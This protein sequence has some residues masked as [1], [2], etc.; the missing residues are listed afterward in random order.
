M[1]TDVERKEK[2]ISRLIEDE[3]KQSYLEYSMSVIVGR[4]LPDVRDGLKPVHRRIL[5]AM[6][7][8]SMLHN[9]PFKKSARIVGEVLGK[10]HP[11]GDTA[12]YESM[13]RMVQSFSLRSPLIQGQGNFGSIDG[14]RA[15]AMR[16]TEARLNKLS[17]EMLQDLDKET[18]EYIPNFDNSLKEPKV[19]PCKVPNLLINGSSGIA[20]GMATNMPPHNLREVCTGM[21]ELINDPNKTNSELMQYISGPD[22]PTGGIIM[23]TKGIKDAYSTGRGK[24]IVRAKTELEEVKNRT[25]IIIKEIPY[26]VNKSLL[27]E[28]IANLT[29]DKKI[30]GISDLRD[31][32]DKD[33]MRIMIELKMGANSDVVLNQLFRHT[34]LQETFG[35]INLALV[36]Y[37]P[38]IL[39]LKDLMEEF[40]KHRQN[41]VRKR[42][43]YDLK[44]ATDKAHLLE[45][46]IIALENIDSV[47]KLIK[48]AKTA[49]E[50]KARLIEQYDLSDKQA[51][52]IL[53]MRL[54]RLTG[55]EQEKVR[56]EHSKLQQ[57]I[58]ILKE[59]LGSEKKIFDIIK[60]ELSELKDKYGDDRRTQIVET[61]AVDLDEET[62][63][64]AEDAVITVTHSGYIK[65]LPI[66]TYKQQKRGGRGIV[67]AETKSDDYVEKLVIANTHDTMLFFTN[68]GKVH[69]LKVF[70]VPETGRYARGTAI[71][72]LVTLAKDERITA[73][74]NIKEFSKEHNVLF[75]TKKGI[76]KAFRVK[77]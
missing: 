17:E 27:I 66:E 75:V 26:M 52:A 4:A 73:F 60:H 63:I 39:S 64:K 76:I 47:I 70:K 34:R 49:Q 8:M 23:G 33:G 19:L 77:K 10:Y 72:N 14:D 46:L 45:G 21:I 74:A 18:V 50:A 62:L 15:A 53:E 51:Q 28:N 40:I 13:V 20:V 56:G 61:S 6:Y 59:I 2:V 55:L 12:V 24:I 22:F 1:S 5:F 54:H 57:L 65:R 42:V 44:Q 29:R 43:E 30:T 48:A 38:K 35:I 71:V 36:D 69:W 9:K 32:S 31:E 58:K 41:I 3:M 7:D 25:R 37:Q 16:Y 67:A 11:H 68:L